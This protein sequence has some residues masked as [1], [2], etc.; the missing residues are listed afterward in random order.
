MGNM[1]VLVGP[2]TT[3]VGVG[4][5]IDFF[6]FTEMNREGHFDEGGSRAQCLEGIVIHEHVV[7]VKV[8][9]ADDDAVEGDGG[10]SFGFKKAIL[11]RKK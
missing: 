9:V 3:F 6:F 1:F 2:L 8:G 7:F 5:E 11:S 4:I 10:L